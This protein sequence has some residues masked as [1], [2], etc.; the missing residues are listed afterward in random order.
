MT[1]PLDTLGTVLSTLR[2][3][4]T[5]PL[6]NLIRGRRP[7]I[8]IFIHSY[9]NYSETYMHEEIRSLIGQYD[10]KIITLWPS[11]YPRKDA[12]PFTLIQYNETSLVYGPIEEVNRE[13]SSPHQQEFIEEV[14][15]IIKDFKPDVMHAH[16][17]GL[18]LLLNFLGERHKIPFTIRTHSMDILSEPQEKID[19]LCDAANSP[20]CKR[21]LAFPAFQDYLVESGLRPEKVVPCW[22]VVNFSRFFKPDHRAPTGKIACAGPAIPKKAHSDFIDLAMRMR[23]SGLTFDLYTKGPHLATT[24]AYNEQAKNPVN[25][26]YKDPDD[27]PDVYPHYDWFVYPSDPTLNKVGLP[28]AIAEAQANGL[29]VCW[30]ELPGRRDEQLE[31]LGGGGYLFQCIEELP[32]ILTQPYP[33]EMRQ[34]GLNNAKKCDIE[35]HKVLLTE[36]WEQAIRKTAAAV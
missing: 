21:V 26:I 20:W 22:P 11:G 27:M 25:I 17:F 13:F 31:F 15:A 12:F 7:R 32:A 29:G 18:G 33:D 35:Q 36:A 14:D 1:S 2:N 34:A 4:S 6:K 24:Q 16:Y 9:P 23:E 19:A 5:K 30:Q 28:A 10:F 3:A 8:L